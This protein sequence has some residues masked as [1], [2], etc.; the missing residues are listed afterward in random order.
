MIELAHTFWLAAILGSMSVLILL[1]AEVSRLD[2]PIYAVKATFL[3]MIGVVLWKLMVVTIIN[4]C[5]ELQFIHLRRG[6]R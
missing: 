4:R 1:N 3:V 2:A 5:Q 6:T